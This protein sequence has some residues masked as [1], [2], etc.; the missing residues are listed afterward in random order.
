MARSRPTLEAQLFDGGAL[1]VGPVTRD[2]RGQP[3]SPARSFTAA[4]SLFREPPTVDEDERGVVEPGPAPGPARTRPA[5]H[6]RLRAPVGRS[7]CASSA[8]GSRTEPCPPSIADSCARQRRPN[9][10]GRG[11]PPSK[12][13]SKR[14]TSSERT[15]GRAET[16]ALQREALRAVAAPRV[17]PTTRPSGSRVCW[18]RARVNF[19]DDDYVDALEHRARSRGED[20]VERLGGRDEDVRRR[21]HQPSALRRRR[22]PRSNAD[23]RRTE[24][25]AGA[26]TPCSRISLDGPP[27]ILLDVDRQRFQR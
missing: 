4:A 13:P 24:C 17:A 11:T 1:L 25:A 19:V 3:P 18:Q 9:A 21:S 23:P 16:N 20:E 6:S 15:L 22:V 27:E 7:S 14:A 10:L 26:A 8:G 2:E 5:R 12:P